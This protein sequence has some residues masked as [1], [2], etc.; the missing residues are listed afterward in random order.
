MPWG[1]NQDGKARRDLGCS[2]LRCGRVSRHDWFGLSA[3]R[4][5][6][7]GLEVRSRKSEHVQKFT[8]ASLQRATRPLSD[9]YSSMRPG[10]VQAWIRGGRALRPEVSKIWPEETGRE[11]SRV[12]VGEA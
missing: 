12:G 8:V 6:P 4:G 9:R 5:S 7:F 3:G 11:T 2:P 10:I 1:S